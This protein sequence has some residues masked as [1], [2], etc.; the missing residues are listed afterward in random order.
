MAVR[1]RRVM[2]TTPCSRADEDGPDRSDAGRRSRVRLHYDASCDL[3]AGSVDHLRR[4]P[5][6]DSI[7]MVPLPDGTDAD[8][9]VLEDARGR[10]ERSTAVL[11]AMIHAGGAGKVFGRLG[12]LVPRPVR[13]AVY[14]VVA[15][16]RHRW[17]R[18]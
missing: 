12:L 17:S 15:R 16:R 11:R 10:H 7:E 3:C 9:M 5:G 6:G 1:R 8:T 2:T 14:G 13:D 4:R 18:R